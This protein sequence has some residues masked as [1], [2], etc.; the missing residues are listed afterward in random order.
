MAA[1]LQQATFL[2]KVCP[3]TM[4][5]LGISPNKLRK[6]KKQSKLKKLDDVSVCNE[7]ISESELK[8]KSEMTD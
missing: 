5:H 1:I 3:N 2:K 8:L 6:I 4:V 7:T